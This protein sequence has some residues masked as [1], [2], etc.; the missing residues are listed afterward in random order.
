VGADGYANR[1]TAAARRYSLVTSELRRGINKVLVAVSW[2]IVPVTVLLFW[3]Q[4]HSQ[5]G[6]QAAVAD[7]TWRR[8]VVFAVAGVVGMIPEGLVLLTSIN[9]ALAAAI[10]ARSRV[11]VQELPAVEVLARVDV[12]CLDKTGTLTD[13]T[14][15]LERIDQL[16]PRPGARAAL[17][18]F[19]ADPDANA[20]A[21]ALGA[22][23]DTDPGIVSPP[24]AVVPFSS[25]RKWSALRTTDGCWVLGA[26]EVVLAGRDDDAA[27]D[28]LALVRERADAGFRVVVLAAA[29]AGLPD[30]AR[31]LPPDLVPTAVGVLRERVRPDAARTLRFFREQGVEVKVLSGDNPTTVAAI[32]RVVDLAGTGEE[33][34]GVDARELPLT[35]DDPEDLAAL[36]A[37]MRRERVLGRVMPEQKRAIVTA[38]QAEG[39]TVAMTG[40]GVNDALA[41]KDAD[42]GIAMGNGAGATKAVARIVL[43]DGR[44]ATLPG[45][46]AQGRR[47][48]ANMERVSNLFLT[49]TTYAA[50]LALAVVVLAWP[51]PFLPRH[52]TLVGAL[53]IGIPAFVLALPPN[54]RRYVPGFLPRVLWFAVPSGVVAAAAVLTVYSPLH[55]AGEEGQARTGATLVLLVVG[56][57]VLGI[58]ARPWNWWRLTLVA[59]MGAAA[60]G[61]FLVPFVREFFALEVPTPTTAVLVL[62]AG[63]VGCA[64]V[65]LVHRAGRRRTSPERVSWPDGRL[66]GAPRPRER[67]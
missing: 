27:R 59:S 57:W 34:R 17:A 24:L 18:A 3:S 4:L 46:L 6:L 39:R 45:V 23:V 29:P 47:V 20:T 16:A 49:K 61:A 64:L 60:V 50:L 43:L 58:L 55:L 22:G 65:E 21:A 32:A 15:V 62:V 54:P 25:A 8:A 41:L 13:G 12:L 2:I 42:L 19:A 14:I 52:L 40:D 35:A 26:P 38:L 5:G 33:V 67:T 44:F 56:L 66:P 36:R 37:V 11:L 31:L 30:P 28:A 53:T 51:Y 9:F 63:G 7:G 10:L 48:I 1:L